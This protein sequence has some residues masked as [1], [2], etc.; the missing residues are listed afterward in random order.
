[1]YASPNVLLQTGALFL[2]LRDFDWDAFSNRYPRIHRA[3]MYVAGVSYGVYFVHPLVLDVLKNGYI[4]GLH[5][6]P[7]NFFNYPVHPAIAGPLVAILAIALS[8]GII[9]LLGKSA[10][11][12]KWLM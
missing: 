3:T 2:F 8:V 1:V 7:H 4:F 11:V 6:N 12:K 9:T 5:V 10:T